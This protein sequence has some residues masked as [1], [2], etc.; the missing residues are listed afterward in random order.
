MIESYVK[1]LHLF[2]NLPI[3]NKLL[4][5]FFA[6]VNLLYLE[7]FHHNCEDIK[8]YKYVQMHLFAHVY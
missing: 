3:R 6:Q 2:H 5:I 7:C 4:H 8:I 1:F